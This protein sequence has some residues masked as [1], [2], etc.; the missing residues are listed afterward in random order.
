[1][2]EQLLNGRYRLLR[3]LGT[4]G[5]ASVYLAEDLRLGRRVAVKVLHPQFASDPSFV[6]R[7]AYEARI[8][9]GLAHP[10]IVQV[11]DVGHDGDRHYIVM[12][13]V[14]GETLKDL[15]TRQ[16]ALPVARALAIIDGV[17]AALE[18][19]HAHNLIHRDIK[20]QN[21]L[22]TSGGDVKV[23]DF[24]IARA[25]SGTAMPTLTLADMVLGTVHYFAPEQAQGRPAVPQSDVYAAGIVLYE[26]LTGTLPF[27]AENPLAVAMQ[28]IN[29]VPTRPT[30]LNPAIPPS[31]EAIVLK[32][33][34]KNPAERFAGAAEMQAAVA[35]ARSGA[36]QPTRA[37]A[38]APTTA[39]R[40]FP[41]RSASRAGTRSAAQ[42]TARKTSAGRTMRRALWLTG[43]PLVVAAAALLGYYLSGG[44]VLGFG[45]FGSATPTPSVTPQ[46]TASATP[47]PTPAPTRTPTA[48]PLPPTATPRPTATP[49]ARA[50]PTATETP[51]PTATPTAAPS[52]T[53]TP[54][55]A[56]PTTAI[57][58]TAA[59]LPNGGAPA[60]QFTP[61]TATAGGN[62]TVTGS[63]WPDGATVTLSA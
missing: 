39:M 62:V 41:P 49:T 14:E 13:F 57:T 21:I 51:E 2:I 18:L 34:A 46:P 35:A 44:N 58:P 37:M 55:T 12:E 19:A 20:A 15:I 7:F 26:M 56:T 50:T 5:M 3:P 43:A 40:P 11:Y 28:Q 17:L 10:H 38:A 9:A 59:L 32:A 6:A 22:L 36:A 48:T 52:A 8:A 47:A 45:G 29:Q 27:D 4:G 24:G 23:T 53:P 16:G 63:G 30:R 42:A 1:M 54:A 25:F 60:I 33:L 31:V 61:A